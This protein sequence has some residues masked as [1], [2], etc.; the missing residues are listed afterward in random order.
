MYEV[1]AADGKAVAVAAYLPYGHLGVGHLEACG[2]CCRTAVDG[3][4]TV[5]VHIIGQTRAAA[6]ARDYRYAVR[7]HAEFGHC[8]V[9]RV[10]NG[11]VAAARTPAYTLVALVIGCLEF[12]CLGTAVFVCELFADHCATVLREFMRSTAATS[13]L[14]I[15]G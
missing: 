10:K 3:V 13:S 11:V 2:D 5:G 6:D 14:T 7:G 15:K 9:E 8:L 4:E 12:L 1:V